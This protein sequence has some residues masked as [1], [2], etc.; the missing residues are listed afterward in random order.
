MYQRIKASIFRFLSNEDGPTSVE[1][2]VMIF[3]IFL[4]V[5]ALVQVIGQATSDSMQESSD[6]IQEAV[7]RALSN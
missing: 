5:I 1:Y 2:A 7:D 4:A 3:S 6:Q